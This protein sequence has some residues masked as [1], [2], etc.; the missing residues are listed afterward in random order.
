MLYP[1]DLD[2]EF[3]IFHYDIGVGDHW[4]AMLETGSISD[5]ES[6][7]VRLPGEE[8]TAKLSRAEARKILTFACVF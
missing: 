3:S 8:I 1:N 2:V 6:K 5:I 7:S 4:S